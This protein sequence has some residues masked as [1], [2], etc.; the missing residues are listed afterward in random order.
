MR[1][2]C[3]W[4]AVSA[5]ALGASASGAASFV[6]RDL[7]IE[8]RPDGTL[9]ERTAFTLR[10]GS[11]AD[12]ERWKDYY[13]PLDDTA[14]LVS[15]KAEAVNPGN[16]RLRG[17]A[18]ERDRLAVP[19]PGVLADSQRYERVS[20]ANLEPGAVLEIQHTVESRPYFPAALLSLTAGEAVEALRVEAR[21]PASLAWHV[22]APSEGLAVEPLPGLGVRLVGRDLP[23]RRSTPYAPERYEQ[24]PVL[25]LRW[26]TDAS[27]EG[28]GR[29]Y[30]ELLAQVRTDEP[31]VTAKALELV[32][33]AR[34]QREKLQA[35]L[36][37]VQ[38]KVRYEAVE[39]GIGGFRPYPAAK[40]LEQR[41]GDCKAKAQLLIEMARA[42]GIEAW[43]LLIRSDSDGRIEE[44]FATPY[45]FNHLIVAVPTSAVEVEPGDPVAD[46]LLFVD[47]TQNR[48]PLAWLHR[49]VQGQRALLVEPGGA[50]LVG[51]PI[52]PATGSR[53]LR[54]TLNLAPDGSAAGGLG[55]EIVGHTAAAL[56]DRLPHADPKSLE[57][58]LRELLQALLPG[59]SV[60]TPSW[61]SPTPAPLP[62]LSV[63]AAIQL[64]ALRQGE[65]DRPT[66]ALPAFT[67]L[68]E[69]RHLSERALPLLLTPGVLEV[70]WKVHLPPGCRA[71]A[72]ELEAANAIGRVE[73]A[74]TSDEASFTLTRRTEIAARWLEASEAPKLAELALAEHRSA[75]RRLRLECSGV[76]SPPADP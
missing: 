76:R 8:V 58:E 22:A 60:G 46:G 1:R 2:A 34:T 68:P 35:L 53:R 48:G 27:W 72:T 16:R 12:V 31:A 73:V 24:G 41:W 10:L 33:G 67:A 52:L 4:F 74:L 3:C 55:L 6:T 21:G 19:A 7:T 11:S 36:G 42:A 20:F 5:L 71:E 49:G 59:A 9:V 40:T 26:S 39:I 62:T 17:S 29:W 18:I 75:R 15:L 66:L 38:E 64:P 25:Y 13:V 14:K 23:G 47:P 32:A 50:R 28:V 51:T 65:G 63:A 37:F 45:D 70:L 56:L 61:S 30:R 57:A 44:S 69:P 54:V 43:P